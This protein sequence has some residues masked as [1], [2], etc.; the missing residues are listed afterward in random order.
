MDPHLGMAIRRMAAR[1]NPPVLFRLLRALWLFALLLLIAVAVY[2][3]SNRW[4]RLLSVVL[5]GAVLLGAL[6]LFWRKPV[7]RWTLLAVVAI[8]AVLILGPNRGLPSVQVL[9]DD[10]LKGMQRY[11]GVTYFWVAKVCVASIAPA[12]C[13]VG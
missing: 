1:C 5:L 9:R 3:V 10:Y 2:P 13:V 6:A 4:S 8:S 7:V 12:W 11:E